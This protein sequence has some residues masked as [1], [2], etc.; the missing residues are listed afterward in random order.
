MKFNGIIA[1]DKDWEI[2]IECRWFC[3]ENEGSVT[4]IV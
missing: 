4:Y 2:H 1:S 3:V